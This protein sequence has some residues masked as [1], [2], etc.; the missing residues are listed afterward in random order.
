MVDFWGCKILTKPPFFSLLLPY[1]HR[2]PKHSCMTFALFLVVSFL[3]HYFTILP[4]ASLASNSKSPNFT[5]FNFQFINVSGDILAF[6][7]NIFTVSITNSKSDSSQ[8]YFL[9]IHMSIPA[10]SFGPLTLKLSYFHFQE[11]RKKKG[12]EKEAKGREKKKKE[13]KI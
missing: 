2:E 12:G 3:F 1:N 6:L 10:P 11:L 13:R 4:L 8:Y 9:I 5:T 7:N